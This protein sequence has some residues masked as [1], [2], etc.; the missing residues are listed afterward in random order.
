MVY[1][2]GISIWSSMTQTQLT[3]ITGCKA[4]QLAHLMQIQCSF[5][6][7]KSAGIT[8]CNKRESAR[9]QCVFGTLSESLLLLAWPSDTQEPIAMGMKAIRLV[10]YTQVVFCYSST[11]VIS[12][13]AWKRTI[14]Q[15]ALFADAYQGL[16]DHIN[17]QLR[18][19]EIDP[20]GSRTILPSTFLGGPR[21]MKQCYHDAMSLVRKYGKPDLFITFTCN[22]RWPEI[23]D[24]IPCWLKAT[25]RHDLVARVFHAKLKEL[26][27]DITVNTLFG[28]VDAYVYTIEFQKR[29][30][31]HAHIL[32]IMDEDSK[33]L[34]AEDVDSVVCA[35]LPDPASE[36]RQLDSVKSHMIHGPEETVYISDGGYPTYRRPNNGLVV[37][38][39]GHPVVNEFVVPYNPYLLVKYDAHINVEVCSTVKSLMYLY[40]YVYNGHDAAILEIWNGDEIE[41]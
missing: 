4:Y 23:V 36:R 8:T 14:Y 35:Y 5:H 6:V 38:V 40:K 24:N 31:P 16:L 33:L 20:V 29:G 2:Q 26:M 25:D 30:L 22:L 21:Y 13:F 32:I 10:Y 37:N 17:Q 19:D 41:K 1:H 39:R 12:T 27:R 15:K 34:T 3:Q 9:T 18:L 11:Y 7:E 28:N